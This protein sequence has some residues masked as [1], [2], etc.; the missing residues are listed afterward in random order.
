MMQSA[1]FQLAEV[2]WKHWKRSGIYH[3]CKGR[4]SS[5][6]F[7]GGSSSQSLWCDPRAAGSLGLSWQGESW[8]WV[9]AKLLG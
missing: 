6:S 1:D 9:M 5:S 7:L 2:A 3:F 4:E 8:G